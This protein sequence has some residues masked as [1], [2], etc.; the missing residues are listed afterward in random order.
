MADVTKTTLIKVEVEGIAQATEQTK[1]LTSE[2]TKQETSIAKL[3]E[4]NKRLTKERNEVNIN[5]KEGQLRLKELNDQL[6]SNNKKIKENVDQ[7]TK[8]KIGIGD[9]KGA[10]D[11]LI[12]GLGATAEGFTSMTT[13]AKAF[14]ATP[15]GAVIGAIGV[16]LGALMAYLKNTGS[17][18]DAL[19]EKTAIL[20][21]AFEQL[22]RGVEAVGRVV[23]QS[24]EFIAGA[25]ERLISFLS[26]A[27]GAAITAAKEAGAA[28]A[29][30]EDDIDKRDTE[31]TVKRAETANQVAKLRAQAL[32][33]EGEERKA[34]IEKAIQLE[35][36]LSAE[37][38]NLSKMRLEL[39]EK[40][41]A[42]KTDLT[43]EEERKRAELQAAVI[44]ADTDAY[45][46]TLRFEKEIER[47]R[48]EN[49]KAELA[50]IEERR[51]AKEAEN[52]MI[53]RSV[54]F[55]TNQVIGN[56]DI[57]LLKVNESS[58]AQIKKGLEISSK[59]A[60]QR[61]KEQQDF[62]KT[63]Q[64]KT[65]VSQLEA[66]NRLATISSTLGQASALF[67]QDSVAYKFLGIARATID[68]YRAANLAL[69]S[70]PPPFGGI[71]AGIAIATGLANVAKISGLGFAE[72]G[73]TGEGGKHEPAGI[74]HRGEYVVPQHIVKNPA[75]SGYIST[76]E[77]ARQRGYADGGL[78][79]NSA[80]N[81]IN[82]QMMM[83]K[84]FQGM[85]IWASWTEAMQMDSNVKFKESISTV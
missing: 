3:R 40:E 72:G 71:A 23:F 35:K 20:R 83:A 24:I 17:G 61:I 47:I 65:R 57:K 82:Q 81:D 68:T 42:T 58:D 48:D 16:A 5:S 28:I 44:A 29:K 49:H 37:E 32:S 53:A 56:E 75:Y 55:E 1:G 76:L 59:L 43:D 2:I 26:P 52:E 18:Q 15:L 33:Q 60:A 77:A 70:Y 4:E 21:L 34:T 73:F 22:M 63:E 50:R 41:H 64:L 74:V 45:N 30:L 54:Q 36:D 38:V 9:Y 66:Q 84:A 27:A 69:A 79:T 62:Q 7:Y 39:W 78:V 12:P 51:L 46:N 19:A 8:Q 31:L 67:E 80:T 6:D 85:Q 10:L 13:T 25:A 11:K 14:I